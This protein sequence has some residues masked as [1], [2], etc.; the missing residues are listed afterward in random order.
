[1][2]NCCFT[3]AGQWNICGKPNTTGHYHNYNMIRIIV[4][5][6]LS[7]VVASTG[8]IPPDVWWLQSSKRAS[9]RFLTSYHHHFQ[10]CTF[11]DHSWTQVAVV[12]LVLCL[13]LYVCWEYIDGSK[14]NGSSC[15]CILV[16]MSKSGSRKSRKTFFETKLPILIFLYIINT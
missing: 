14:K 2:A 13:T 4:V 3:S 16:E 15:I 9:P 10:G 8:T 6:I 5:G 7:T 1:M 11:H 12:L